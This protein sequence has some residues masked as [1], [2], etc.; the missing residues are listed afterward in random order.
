LNYAITTLKRN[1]AT[2]VYLDAGHS[3]WINVDTM[4]NRL[5]RAGLESADGFALNVSNFQT[6]ANETAYGEQISGLVGGKHFVIDTARNGN[7]SNGE[8]CNPMGRAIG[9]HPTTNTGRPLIDAL[10]WLKTPGESDGLCNG[11]P[12]AGNWW[13][14]YAQALVQ[15]RR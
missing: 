12:A 9:T 13:P 8:W 5:K 2:K 3:G 6:T 4:A 14:E 10:L 1:G 7:G 15:N 11:G